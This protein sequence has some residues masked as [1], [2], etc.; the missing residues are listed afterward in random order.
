MA[1]GID[2]D[3][4]RAIRD[5]RA[6]FSAMEAQN[7]G[8]T[9]QVYEAIGALNI[10]YPPGGPGSNFLAKIDVPSGDAA[11]TLTAA[12]TAAGPNGAVVIGSGP[13]TL[14][15]QPDVYGTGVLGIGAQLAGTVGIPGLTDYGAAKSSTF[16]A[17][18]LMVSPTNEN[19]WYMSG[20]LAPTAATAGYQKN[21]LYVTLL[22]ADPSSYSSAGDANNAA[23]LIVGKDG[24]GLDVQV[25]LTPGNMT[26]RLFGM[27][28][29]TSY[30]AGSDGAGCS[31]E[32]K[33]VN[34]ASP[35]PYFSNSNSKHGL[36]FVAAGLYDITTA[37]YMDTAESDVGAKFT[38][39]LFAARKAVRQSLIT[40]RETTALGSK[41]Y[42]DVSRDG[43][44]LSSGGFDVP[45]M[46]SA[47]PVPTAGYGRM[48][49]DPASGALKYR[50]S[51][52]QSVRANAGETVDLRDF[53]ADFTGTNDS[54]SAL[55]N[56]V[57]Q[58]QA[59]KIPLVIPSG[60][61]TTTA[62]IFITRPLAIR[63]LSCGGGQ[64]YPS[65]ALPTASRLHFAH[66]GK[67]LYI[68]KSSGTL[69]GVTIHDLMTSRPQTEPGSGAWA[70]YDSDYD[71]DMLNATDVDL[72]GLM[73]WNATRG[74]NIFGSSRVSVA[75]LKMQ[76][77]KTGICAD[78]VGDVCRF[79]NVHVW[80]FWRDHIE[81]HRYALEN[82]DALHLKRI[83]TPFIDNF[84][85]IG[86]RS[87]LR[88]SSSS[89][90]SVTKLKA[91][92]VDVDFS[93]RGLWLDD[94][95]N[96]VTIDHIASLTFQ[97][98]L[99]VANF[100]ETANRI[101]I[102][103]DSP[104]GIK[105]VGNLSAGGLSG[106]AVAVTKA[107]A[108]WN[109]TGKVQTIGYGGAAGNTDPAFTVASGSSLN[110]SNPLRSDAPG[111]G[112]LW[113]GAGKLRKHIV[114]LYADD[115]GAID[116]TN[117]DVVQNRNAIVAHYIENPGKPLFLRA[118]S[119]FKFG[120]RLDIPSNVALV[121]EGSVKPILYMPAANFNRTDNTFA[122]RYA[123][124]AVGIN[125]TSSTT[126]V[127][128]VT[129]E[130]FDLVSEKVSGRAIRG[131]VARNAAN[132]TVAGVNVSGLPMGIGFC[133]AS[134]S[135]QT[136]I[137][138]C[139]AFDFY[140]N[141]VWDPATIPQ[142]TAFEFD[143]DRIGGVGTTR[144]RFLDNWCDSIVAGPA[145]LAAHGDQTD[146][147]N[148]ASN[149]FRY[150]TIGNFTGAGVGELI[151]C[152]GSFN[153]FSNISGRNIGLFGLKLIYGASFN[154]V[155][156]LIADGVGLAGLVIAGNNVANDTEGNKVYGLICRN[157]DPNNTRAGDGC[158]VLFLNGNAGMGQPRNNLVDGA[159][160]DL[161]AYSTTGWKDQSL[162][163]NNHGV[164]IQK[165]TGASLTKLAVISAR[166]SA[167]QFVGS[168]ARFQTLGLMAPVPQTNVATVNTASFTPT[169]FQRFLTVAVTGT[170]T[171]TLPP[172]W[173]G[174][175][176]DRNNTAAT[177][178]I[179]IQRTPVVSTT[180]SIAGTM[181]TVTA[182]SAYIHP[183]AVLDTG[184]VVD[185]IRNYVVRQITGTGTGGA[186]MGGIGTYEVAFADTV[187]SGSLA[188][189]A[190]GLIADGNTNSATVTLNTNGATASFVYKGRGDGWRRTA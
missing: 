175:I 40:M 57:D 17:S 30:P 135:G 52:G 156:G 181:M 149:T 27:D 38:Y 150:N 89:A 34:N 25:G 124:N 43:V 90:G 98:A 146:G 113:G 33:I 69:A 7:N 117:G 14:T 72:S 84:F 54:T 22:H 76:A 88:I 190:E 78:V 10:D 159:T 164:N 94:T 4:T 157:V 132:L 140:D 55:Q 129:L 65:N 3:N 152:F 50:A 121:G 119:F 155:H 116:G 18:R 177:N 125:I 182:A 9:V 120:S 37:L 49:I 170:C 59:A 154:T 127:T 128:N 71:I 70:P 105:N 126:P 58:A 60:R 31:A 74:I 178:N 107:G 176:E 168:P 92:K 46:S 100:P 109:L 6:R 167:V 130:N 64:A 165:P 131:I 97:G 77:F 166:D 99:A 138:N 102:F 21:T 137:Q 42:F 186:T 66:T 8:L 147:F 11:G 39:G 68:N 56:A 63:G 169:L 96:N 139:G 45:A 104:G 48:Y 179:V 189:R 15:S 114:K 79:D 20:Y 28:V 143:N 103:D 187:A 144:M 67:G 16:F 101:A 163:S 2:I 41:T 136:L 134:L 108:E 36:N 47:P 162:G 13:F 160:I 158:G 91:G 161:G 81:V 26:G 82:L 44:T 53:G 153:E 148:A 87:G 111:A 106:S 83:D 123:A 23:G 61:I 174:T 183:G 185:G 32:Y 29:I 184:I 141:G 151:D 110:L 51:D 24:V 112:P 95:A 171:I 5:L 1:I 12:A 73:L 180:A 115:V 145:F 85:A 86:T 93:K 19:A 75:D 133:F 173:D 142:L 118:G 80:P 35:A 122:N 62:P 188:L 172:G